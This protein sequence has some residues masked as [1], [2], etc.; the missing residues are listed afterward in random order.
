MLLSLI[1]FTLLFVFDINIVLFQ[2]FAERP[3]GN[4]FRFVMSI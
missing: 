4:I 3:R 2:P 1:L